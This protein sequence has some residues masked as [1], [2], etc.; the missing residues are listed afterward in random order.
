MKEG[1]AEGLKEGHAEGLKEGLKEGHAEGLK[2]GRA[3][4]LKEGLKESTR[5]I[6][7]NLKR[8]GIPLSDIVK[9]T[10]LSESQIE[11]L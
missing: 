2:E 11:E 1:H 3:E 7:L 10:G 5:H 6:A 4:G 9:A 8:M